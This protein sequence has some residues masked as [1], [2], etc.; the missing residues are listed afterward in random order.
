MDHL[1]LI[2]S[3]G[4]RIA[5]G[6]SELQAKYF[7]VMFFIF[8]VKIYHFDVTKK[9]KVWNIRLTVMNQ[10]MILVRYLVLKTWMKMC[11][12]RLNNTSHVSYILTHSPK[13]SLSYI[14]YSW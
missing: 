9:Q 5:V 14:S 10:M 3:Q 7:M 2:E 8:M 6:Q 11:I 4:H 12:D 13:E 1:Q